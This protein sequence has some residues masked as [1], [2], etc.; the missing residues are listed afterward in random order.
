MS[1]ELNLTIALAMKTAWPCSTTSTRMVSSSTM[2]PAPTP[3]P[4]SVNA[5]NYYYLR[6]NYNCIYWL[7][8][9]INWF[10]ISSAFFII[11][12]SYS[13]PNCSSKNSN[14]P[15]WCND[16]TLS[17]IRSGTDLPLN[18]ISWIRSITFWRMSGSGSPPTADS[19]MIF[20]PFRPPTDGFTE[21]L[22]SPGTKSMA[23][24]EGVPA[25]AGVP[26]RDLDPDLS[27][28]ARKFFA[29]R[30]SLCMSRALLELGLCGVDGLSRGES[31]GTGL[32][33]RGIPDKL[34]ILR[35]SLFC[36]AMMLKDP[37][38]ER[39]VKLSPIYGSSLLTSDHAAVPECRR[40]FTDLV[41]RS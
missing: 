3:N 2:L 13:S 35:R 8:Q 25:L 41:S 34:S 27:K 12:R 37:I 30:A 17:V 7:H 19:G 10:K 18:S 29:L 6:N 20:Q 5:N 40:G 24:L 9:Y 23:S 28:L 4:H 32:F 1:V 26:S 15:S 14:G 39:Q 31:G 11:N 38:S 36:E 21:K 33:F 22:I 16:H